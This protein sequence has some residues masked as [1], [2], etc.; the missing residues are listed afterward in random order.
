[1][2][3]SGGQVT[4]AYEGALLLPR[5][6]RCGGLSRRAGEI[7]PDSQTYTERE[8]MRSRIFQRYGEEK[9]TSLIY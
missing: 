4:A 6:F 8:H 1:M 7:Q 9:W 2:R 5:D 3:Q